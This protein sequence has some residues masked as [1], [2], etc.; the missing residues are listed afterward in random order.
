MLL[1]KT[2]KT[3]KNPSKITHSSREANP[4]MPNAEY[5]IEL[6]D[7]D[8]QTLNPFLITGLA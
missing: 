1:P 3:T 2:L 6:I 7:S 4:P 8:A 5:L